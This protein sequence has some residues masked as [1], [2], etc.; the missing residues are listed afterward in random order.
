MLTCGSHVTFIHFLQ[1]AF[2]F[3][4]VFSSDLRAI[5]GE[6]GG[7]FQ[8]QNSSIASVQ[9]HTTQSHQWISSLTSSPSPP[10]T[11]RPSPPHLLPLMQVAETVAALLRR[12]CHFD[13]RHAMLNAN[14]MTFGRRCRPNIPCFRFILLI[15]VRSPYIRRATPHLPNPTSV[16]FVFSP[17]P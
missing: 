6:H 10:T 17:L 5:K 4:Y 1:A 3:V 14:P 12:W 2:K 11:P 13:H 15:F 8:H 16:H 7:A 9:P